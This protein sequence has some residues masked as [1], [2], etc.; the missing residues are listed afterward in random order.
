MFDKHK[1]DD[2]ELTGSINPVANAMAAMLP[3]QTGLP[4]S[5]LAFARVAAA[6]VLSKGD[7]NVSQSW[8][9]PATGARGSV[10]PLTSS[11]TENG[12]TCREFLASHVQGK[13]ETWLEG[14]ACQNGSKWEV[15][16]LKAWKRS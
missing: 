14:N 11:F 12:N 5:D 8:E 1:Q 15:R 9:N 2:A 4:E 6:D 10:T 13:I 16:T 7:R 3:D